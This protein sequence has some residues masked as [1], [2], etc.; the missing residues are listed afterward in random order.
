MQLDQLR[1]MATAYGD[2]MQ[3][4]EKPKESATEELVGGAAQEGA[5]VEQSS[6]ADSNINN[7]EK[8]TEITA[9]K[10]DLEKTDDAVTDDQQANSEDAMSMRPS[11]AESTSDSES[12]HSVQS[13]T[14]DGE[15]EKKQPPKPTNIEACEHAA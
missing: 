13:L 5:V 15:V 6:T 9:V 8:P 3:Q 12:V 4:Q 2:L 10:A 14:L 7:T 11:Q 1:V